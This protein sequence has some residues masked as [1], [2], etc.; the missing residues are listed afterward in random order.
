MAKASRQDGGNEPEA[1]GPSMT[2]SQAQIA[3]SYA[4]GQHFTFEGASGAC[5]AIPS[6]DAS[7]ARL[8]ATTRVQIEM[9]IDEA[10]KAW[11]DKGINCRQGGTQN[12]VTV[13]PPLPDFCM[14]VS[15]LDTARQDYSFKPQAFA[16]FRPDRMGYLPQPTTLICSQC[17]LIE[18]TDNPR[19]MG[20]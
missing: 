15:L 3:L 11:F 1:K 16:Y 4:P 20:R 10:A 2:R 9:R 7:P 12:G 17:G 5:L 19:H 8:S 13:A 14:H 6:P 18:A